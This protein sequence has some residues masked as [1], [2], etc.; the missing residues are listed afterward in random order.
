MTMKKNTESMTIANAFREWSYTHMPKSRELSANTQR[1]YQEALSLYVAYLSEVVNV[2]ASSLSAASFS[3]TIIEGWLLWLRTDRGCSPAT[4]NHRLSCLRSFLSYLS[5]L[6]IRFI[7]CELES[8]KV[9]KMKTPKTLPE[10]ISQESIATLFKSIDPSSKKGRRDFALFYLMYSIAARIDEILSLRIKH[11]HFEKGTDK[12][13]LEVT[14]KGSKRRTPPIL[15]DVGKVLKAYI[16]M[17]HG[18]NPNPESFLFQSNRTGEAEDKKLTQ[19]AIDKRIKI[20]SVLAHAKDPSIPK[21]MHCHH[22]R[23]ARASHWLEQGL[24]LVSIQRLMGHA[25]INTTSQYIFISTG[26]KIQV[27]TKL[28]DP[29]VQKLGKKWHNTKVAKDL[30]EHMGMKKPSN[31]KQK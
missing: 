19:S 17:F 26:Q 30:F 12:G 25:D 27:L 29:V 5:T 11:L 21:K 8:K 23:H 1:A 24:D 3:A 6:D 18:K 2:T 20:Y 13:Y 16:H 31:K 28:E 7:G 15:Q 4:C 22:L 9:K 10:E 14:G